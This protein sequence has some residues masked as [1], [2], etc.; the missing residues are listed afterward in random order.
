MNSYVNLD[1]DEYLEKGEK[2]EDALLY[3][4][5]FIRNLDY[6]D[7]FEPDI[8]RIEYIDELGEE[9]ITYYDYPNKAYTEK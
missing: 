6:Y 8:Y 1:E 5:K 9:H 7:L 4:F 2:V 3:G